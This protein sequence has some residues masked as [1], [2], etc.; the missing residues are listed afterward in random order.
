[1]KRVCRPLLFVIAPL[2]VFLPPFSA[3]FGWTGPPPCDPGDTQQCCCFCRCCHDLCNYHPVNDCTHWQWE[4]TWWGPYALDTPL[5]QYYVPRSPSC[6]GVDG[7]AWQGCRY[8]SP[9]QLYRPACMNCGD[10]NCL[11]VAVADA[12]MD[13]FSPTQFERLGKLRNELD[14]PGGPLGNPGRMPAAGR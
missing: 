7:Y 4:R 2:I 12:P 5:R 13:G 11:K 9:E 1:M 14:V 6:C 8:A 10:P 3:C